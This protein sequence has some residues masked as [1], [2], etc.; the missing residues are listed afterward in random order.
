VVA[1]CRAAGVRRLLH[2][3]ALG[4][5]ASAPSRY[6]QTKAAGEEAVRAAGATLPF[7]IFRP[8]VVFGEGDRFLNLFADL[9]RFPVLPL[10]GAAARFQP[11]WVEDV[12]RAFAVA[13][14]RPACFGQTYELCGP[15]AYSLE[16]LVRFV[17]A[18]TGRNPRVVP[19][20]SGFAMLQASMLER[21]PGKLMTRDNVRSMSV[22][23]VCGAP[24]PAVLGFQPAALESVVPEYLGATAARGR[25]AAYRNHAGR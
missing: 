21:L 15:R 2:M 14:A 18:T 3:S 22:D 10:G 20:G 25:Y 6:Q 23:N 24:F 16:E 5:S 17:A 4:A 13:L 11:I 19:L 1:A 9:V 7:T 8:S 12:A